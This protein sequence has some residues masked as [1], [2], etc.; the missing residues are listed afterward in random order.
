MGVAIA[1]PRRRRIPATGPRR[2]VYERT[3]RAAGL[4][5]GPRDCGAREAPPLHAPKC[6]DRR[7]Q[8][9]T[10][11][12]AATTM[13]VERGRRP[14]ATCL[15]SGRRVSR[16]RRR[17]RAGCGRTDGPVRRGLPQSRSAPFAVGCS[18]AARWRSASLAL[19]IHFRVL[20][21]RS[22]DDV[23]SRSSARGRWDARTLACAPQVS[24]SLQVPCSAPKA[25]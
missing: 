3:A 21:R 11:D 15:I 18:F 1:V 2:D 8:R 13:T 6:V 9:I 25:S 24:Q 10:G 19:P 5:P 12:V 20:E 17:L 7:A 16:R 22:K 4:P 14:A 23:G